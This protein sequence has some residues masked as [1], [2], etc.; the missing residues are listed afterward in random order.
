MNML[1][2][3]SRLENH[4][5]VLNE[6]DIMLKSFGFAVQTDWAYD[7]GSFDLQ[8]GASEG[9][10]FFLRIPFYAVRGEL[11]MPDVRIRM[12]QPFVISH[13]YSTTGENGFMQEM[14]VP[15]SEDPYAS[16]PD[17]YEELGKTQLQRIEAHLFPR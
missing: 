10:L 14:A 17:H 13:P 3:E 8:L 12:G 4:L 16:I 9:S 11:H 7:Q 1:P 6:L 2:L 15:F 5:A